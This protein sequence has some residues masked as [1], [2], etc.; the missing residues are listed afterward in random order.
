MDRPFD[1]GLL[2]TG[3]GGTQGLY[4]YRYSDSGERVDNITGWAFNEFVSQYGKRVT[5]DAIFYYVYAVLHDPIY[6]ETY[7]LD[8]K[9]EF[10][11]I[12]F[13]SDF[14]QWATWGKALLNLHTGYEKLEPWPITK[15]NVATSRAITGTYARPILRSYSNV[16]T[17]V[18]DTDTEVTGNPP[19]AWSYRLGNRSAIDWVLDQYREKKPR[20]AIIATKFN[21]YRLSDYKEQLIEILAKV[22]RVSVDTVAITDAMRLSGRRIRIE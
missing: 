9:R 2:K 18:I 6:L 7:R 4:R 17:A 15:V 1:Y 13:Y 19:K 22:V 5:R 12:P 3:N 11:R 20:D 21:D 16:G 14:R 10:P 8:L